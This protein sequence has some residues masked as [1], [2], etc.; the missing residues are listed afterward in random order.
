MCTEAN[1]AAYNLSRFSFLP[2]NAGCQPYRLA[3]T[4][5][6][7]TL[8]LPPTS[9]SWHTHAYLPFIWHSIAHTQGQLLVQTSKFHH[10]A[11]PIYALLI[12]THTT[13]M[14]N[15]HTSLYGVAVQKAA[16]SQRA[17]PLGS[18]PKY[19]QS[20]SPPVSSPSIS[21]VL[22]SIVLVRTLKCYDYLLVDLYTLP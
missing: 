20:T 17:D 21:T 11:A 1:I 5:L 12:I 19:I 13:V 10:M 9:N 6:A 22:T 7:A 15:K 14:S 2:S 18:E 4:E 8:L 3:T 16:R